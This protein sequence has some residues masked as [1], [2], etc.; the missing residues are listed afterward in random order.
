MRAYKIILIIILALLIG[1]MILSM[2][3]I[4]GNIKRN[5]EL[6]Y[7]IIFLAIGVVIGIVAFAYHI[8][9][10][11]YYR[12]SKRKEEVVKLSVILWIG[13]VATGVYYLLFGML[14]TVGSVMN[15]VQINSDAFEIGMTICM[16]VIAL[17]GVC[18]L[19]ETSI[20]KKRVKIQREET[21]LH[22]EIDEIGM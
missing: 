10:F 18:S 7:V 14:A 13:A 22:N 19:I 4:Y 20:L 2:I 5:S 12:E 15:G 1:L 8:K 16:A 11:R 17:F 3:Q 9:S 21:K 6:I